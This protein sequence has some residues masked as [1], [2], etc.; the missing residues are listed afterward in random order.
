MLM[1]RMLRVGGWV[2]KDERYDGEIDLWTFTYYAPCAYRYR[3]IV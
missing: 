2:N 1:M 3:K